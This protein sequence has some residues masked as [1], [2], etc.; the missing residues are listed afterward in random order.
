MS[1]VVLVKAFDRVP[2]KVLEWALRKKG[3]PEGLVRS[4]M[5]QYK[6]ANTRVR[7][8]S[9]LSVEFKGD[10]WLHQGSMLSPFLLAVVVDVVTLIE[11][12]GALS[13]L[14]YA[15]DLELMSDTIDG[16]RN[17]FFKRKVSFESKHF[18][19]NLGKTMVEV[20]GGITKDCLHKI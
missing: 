7:M 6:G 11:R 12:E 13:E 20:F 10:V 14:L 19:A 2:R 3:I 16:F 4:V 15:N 9:E 8:D 5:S 1:F 18:K 17:M